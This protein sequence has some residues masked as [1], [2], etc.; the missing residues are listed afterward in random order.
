MSRRD[1]GQSTRLLSPL[2]L[3]LVGL[4]ILVAAAAFWAITE[5]ESALFVGAAL[6][7]IGVG[8]YERTVAKLRERLDAQRNG[9]ER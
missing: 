4:A 5:R 6:T 8:S 9:G 1:N 3:Q 7:L 2:V